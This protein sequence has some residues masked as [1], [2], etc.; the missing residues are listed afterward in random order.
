[1]KSLIKHAYN[2]IPLKKEFF[3]A[4][5]KI[6]KP[7]ASIYQHLH[8]K[9]II[10]VHVD[11]YKSFKMKHYGYQVENDIFWTGLT[12]EWEKHSIITWIKLAAHSEVIL[13]IGAN[14]GVYSLIS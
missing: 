4:L 3:I 12:G 13:D 14:T 10:N 7:K 11:A 8:F 1:M 5:K 9:G 2:L 6:W